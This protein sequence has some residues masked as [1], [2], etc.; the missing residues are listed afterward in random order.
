MEE[1]KSLLRMSLPQDKIHVAK[2]RESRTKLMELSSKIKRLQNASHQLS[3]IT[4]T[5]YVT[6]ALECKRGHSHQ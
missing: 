4:K 3:L 5:D 1:F 6:R 2:L